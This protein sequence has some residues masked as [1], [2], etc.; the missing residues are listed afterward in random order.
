MR[1]LGPGSPAVAGACP[2]FSLWAAIVGPCQVKDTLFPNLLIPPEF[3]GLLLAVSYKVTTG[4]VA[5]PARPNT[6]VAGVLVARLGHHKDG[7]E[8]P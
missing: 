5:V 2:A 8:K 4:S 1:R 6:S 7:G 3:L